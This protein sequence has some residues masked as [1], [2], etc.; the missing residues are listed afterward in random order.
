M[1]LAERS[2]LP[3]KLTY[4]LTVHKAQGMSLD[5]VEIDCL[6]M[7][8]P[9]QLSVA[10]SRVHHK[11]GLRVV[12][13]REYC[14]VKQHTSVTDFYNNLSKEPTVMDLSCCITQHR[15]ATLDFTESITPTDFDDITLEEM[16]HFLFNPL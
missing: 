7:N 2:Q 13:F 16:D 11:E 14:C 3:L 10:I 6:N 5:A 12:N 8:R 15:P 4:A 9:G 1:N